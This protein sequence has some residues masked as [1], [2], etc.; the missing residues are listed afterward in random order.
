M[1]SIRPGCGPDGKVRLFPRKTGEEIGHLFTDTEGKGGMNAVAKVQ[2]D[3]PN[4]L[5]HPLGRIAP[6]FDPGEF[7]RGLI[8]ENE[9]PIGEGPNGVKPLACRFGQVFPPERPYEER[10][11]GETSAPGQ[12]GD[13][14]GNARPGP[15][16]EARQEEEDVSS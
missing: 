16:A 14:G 9:K 6:C 10:E 11:D 3:L 13:H 1:L 2:Q 12:F 8:V 5:I 4:H 7:P 15:P